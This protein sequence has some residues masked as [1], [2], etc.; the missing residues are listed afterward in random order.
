MAGLSLEEF[1]DVLSRYNE[2]TFGISRDEIRAETAEEAMRFF[3]GVA[4]RSRERGLTPEILDSIISE[5]TSPYE[6]DS[7]Q[8]HDMSG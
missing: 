1:H 8:H 3:D 6:S 2:S 7:P 4:H 5:A